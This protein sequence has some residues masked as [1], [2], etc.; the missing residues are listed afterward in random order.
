[1]VET[2]YHSICLSERF[3][4]EDS[5]WYHSLR[6]RS[7]GF[8]VRLSIISQWNLSMALIRM[9]LLTTSHQESELFESHNSLEVAVVQPRWCRYH[10]W[11]LLPDQQ[12]ALLLPL[13]LHHHHLCN[14]YS[15]IIFS[16][17]LVFVGTL[18]S[19]AVS[20]KKGGGQQAE[21]KSAVCNIW[22]S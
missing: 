13:L 15:I 21:T 20:E 7:T 22:Q 1:M 8:C 14:L 2:T 17:F 4:S 11:Q 6:Y 18:S 3:N 5:L 19:S 10:R 16:L 12:L 9:S